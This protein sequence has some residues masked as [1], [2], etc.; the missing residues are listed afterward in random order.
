M[1]AKPDFVRICP[2]VYFRLAGFEPYFPV[3]RPFF[4]VERSRR[5]GAEARGRV[6]WGGGGERSGRRRRA[7]GAGVKG[8]Y[9]K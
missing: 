3:W 5:A 4:G 6:E 9:I 8:K 2:L 1:H 7:E